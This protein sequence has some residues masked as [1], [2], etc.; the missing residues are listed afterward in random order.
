MK[1]IEK[2]LSILEERFEIHKPH[3]IGDKY[4]CGINTNSEY[5]AREF[6]KELSQ[7][8][9]SDS[10]YFKQKP[11]EYTVFFCLSEKDLELILKAKP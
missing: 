6:Q 1:N 5:S 11:D 8:K 10:L 2:Y 7:N 3:R 9:I 4:Q